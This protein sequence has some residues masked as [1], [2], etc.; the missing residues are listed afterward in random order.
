MKLNYL[1]LLIAVLAHV[2]AKKLNVTDL[3]ADYVRDV[4]INNVIKTLEPQDNFKVTL[5]TKPPIL[6]KCKLQLLYMVKNWKSLSMFPSECSC[7]FA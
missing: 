1:A 5:P 6:S 7:I 4:F 3:S 2:S